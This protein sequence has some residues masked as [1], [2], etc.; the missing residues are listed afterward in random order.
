MSI[1]IDPTFEFF[2][3][4]HEYQKALQTFS[5]NPSLESFL[6]FEP[7]PETSL[8][9]SF[10]EGGIVL[11][12][13]DAVVNL[14][15]ASWKTSQSF[16]R[17][18]GNSRSFFDLSR[19]PLRGSSEYWLYRNL[20]SRVIT[21][22]SLDSMSF[23][24]EISLANLTLIPPYD[25]VLPGDPLPEAWIGYLISGYEKVIGGKRCDVI[26]SVDDPID[27]KSFINQLK[28]ITLFPPQMF[29]FPVPNDQR[30]FDVL[31][32]FKDSDIIDVELVYLFSSTY[33]WIYGYFKSIYSDADLSPLRDELN[34]LKSKK[35]SLTT[36]R[37]QFPTLGGKIDLKKVALLWKIPGN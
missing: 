32:L 12:N 28:F 26:G 33:P 34:S 30:V 2:D 11:A 14:S 19:M 7:R 8:P 27:F 3:N 13:L 35:K 15:L 17:I 6:P 36:Q 5:E 31:K 10:L 20:S 21:E 37:N 29:F 24:K 4:S 18:S 25:L 23:R 9:E 16:T 1:K 22:N